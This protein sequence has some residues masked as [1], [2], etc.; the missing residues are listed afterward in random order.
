MP[1]CVEFSWMW[2]LY[3]TTFTSVL[4]SSSSER[5]AQDADLLNKYMFILSRY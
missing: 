4:G 1:R 2:P 3:E 5:T